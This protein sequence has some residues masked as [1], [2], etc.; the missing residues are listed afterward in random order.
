MEEISWR[1]KSRETW[2]K[3]GDMNTSF[4]LRMENAH[5]RRNF[6]QN[7]SINGR[8]LDKEDEIKEGLVNAFQNL[9]SAPNCWRPPLPGL[10]FNVIGPEEASKL[11]EVFTEKEIWAAISELNGDNAPGPDGFP[12]AF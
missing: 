11:E 1:Q 6:L 2:L 3:E 12:I 8:R 4:F 5:R 10:L 7:L 9:L